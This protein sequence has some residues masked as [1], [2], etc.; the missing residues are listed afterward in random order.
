MSAASMEDA[1]DLIRRGQ[2]LI[3]EAI[4]TIDD[5]ATLEDAVQAY[6]DLT[7]PSIFERTLQALSISYPDLA[8]LDIGRRGAQEAT[9][10]IGVAVDEGHGAQYLVL[11]AIASVHFDA[12]HFET[13]L[14]DAATICNGSL[15]L[16]STAGDDDANESLSTSARLLFESITS[17]EA[18]LQKEGD[19]V[20][21]MRRFIK[22]YGELFEDVGGPLFAWYNLLTGL[23]SQSYQKLIATDATALASN[24]AKAP[25]ARDMAAGAAT[26][27]RNA[28]Q[29]GG[30]FVLSGDHI[31]FRLR[32]YKETKTRGEVVNDIFALLE[33]LSAMSWA[34]SNALAHAGLPV[35]ATEPDASYMGF[36][37]FRLASLSLEQQGT[38]VVDSREDPTSWAFTVASPDDVFQLG[39]VLGLSAPRSLAFLTVTN[40]R[41]TEPVTVPLEA[42]Q[43]FA[44]PRQG[45]GAPED[46]LL[47]L[48]ELR[49]SCSWRGRPLLTSNDLR[50]ATATLGLFLLLGKPEVISHVRRVMRL[51]ESRGEAELVVLLRA[52]FSQFRSPEAK[53]KRRLASVLNDLLARSSPPCIPEANCIKVVLGPG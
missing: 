15:H 27:L 7:I 38:G 6:E 5:Y 45:E 16:R 34:L 32:S 33:T 52:A 41:D 18:I 8:L 23:K 29:H 48:L 4:A 20:A 42:Y 53:E 51:A 22:F 35:R 11:N 19:E 28:A 26:Y 43:R 47:A 39:I 24:L 12:P 10:C 49:Q 30:S 50:F 2:D 44:E 25:N 1:R 36:S 14:K 37:A 9:A 3:D 17:F 40:A 21:L 13:L 46:H 31:E